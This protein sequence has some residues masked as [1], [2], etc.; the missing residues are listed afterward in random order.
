MKGLHTS[1]AMSTIEPVAKC[2]TAT[3]IRKCQYFIWDAVII[4]LFSKTHL[5][6]YAYLMLYQTQIPLKLFCFI[7]INKQ[8]WLK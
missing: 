8:F 5:T 7:M 3:K 1:I 6:H 2:G 4:V